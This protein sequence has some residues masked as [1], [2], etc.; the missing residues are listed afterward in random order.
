MPVV[1][2][3]VGRI[4]HYYR[5]DG[6]IGKTPPLA[7]IVTQVRT[8][9]EEAARDMVALAVFGVALMIGPARAPELTMSGIPVPHGDH[10]NQSAFWVWPPRE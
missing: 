9:P 8:A 6:I 7:A 2:P 4:V 1:R 3:T 5:A 10:A